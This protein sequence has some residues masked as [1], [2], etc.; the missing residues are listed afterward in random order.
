MNNI[1]ERIKKLRD[2]NNCTQ[3]ELGKILNLPKQSIS[4]IEKGRRSVSP[5]EIDKISKLFNIPS[6][7][8]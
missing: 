3:T 7:F 4:R 5:E 6:I 8:K 2:R 1:G